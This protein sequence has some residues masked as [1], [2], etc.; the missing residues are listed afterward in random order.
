VFALSGSH[1]EI[2]SVVGFSAPWL[3]QRADFEGAVVIDGPTYGFKGQV[4]D[5]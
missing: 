2:R 4:L 5:T 3:Y 1:S